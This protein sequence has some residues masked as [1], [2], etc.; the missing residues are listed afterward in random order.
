ML[1]ILLENSSQTILDVLAIYA[2]AH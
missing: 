1:R 2:A